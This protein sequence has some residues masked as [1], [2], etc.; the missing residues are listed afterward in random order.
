MTYNACMVNTTQLPSLPS[1]PLSAVPGLSYSWHWEFGISLPNT[2][3][4]V[5]NIITDHISECLQI[6]QSYILHLKM[7]SNLTISVLEPESLRPPAV[8][9]HE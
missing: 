4:S 2:K 7:V 9:N 5:A 8:E 1:P 6:Y 3:D